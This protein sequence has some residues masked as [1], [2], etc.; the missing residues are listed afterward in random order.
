MLNHDEKIIFKDIALDYAKNRLESLEKKVEKSIESDTWKNKGTAIKQ[1]K[2]LK[3]EKENKFK[4]NISKK[5][6]SKNS[7]EEKRKTLAAMS[8]QVN[9]PANLPVQQNSHGKFTFKKIEAPGSSLTLLKKSPVSRKEHQKSD[10]KTQ[11]PSGLS[12]NELALS[13][14]K[15]TPPKRPRG[16]PKKSVTPKMRDSK[17]PTV[18]TWITPVAKRKREEPH[19]SDSAQ[20]SQKFSKELDDISSGLIWTDSDDE[21]MNEKKQGGGFM[22]DT[23]SVVVPRHTQS[24][25]V[26][27]TAPSDKFGVTQARKKSRGGNADHTQSAVSSYSH[28]STMMECPLCSGNFKRYCII[29]SV[30]SNKFSEIWG[31]SVWILKVLLSLFRFLPSIKDPITCCFM[32]YCDILRF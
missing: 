27:G 24:G 15:V 23:T 9:K 8:K 17:Q 4:G 14:A 20:A 11:S 10:L 30:I 5:S 12:R 28:S 7:D 26:L 32:W 29:S 25:N 21:D 31:F 16:Q 6:M 3:K 1:Q 18:N 22:D 2:Q 19:F 13:D